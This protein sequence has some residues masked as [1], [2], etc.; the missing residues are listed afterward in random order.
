MMLNDTMPTSGTAARA[1]S[2]ATLDGGENVIEA[3]LPSRA[4]VRRLNHRPIGD[5]VAVGNADFAQR[6]AAAVELADHV[7]GEVEVRIT[8]R[9]ERHERLAA[10]LAEVGEESVE[11]RH[12]ISVAAESCSYGLDR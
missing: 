1:G 9:N 4:R 6:R 10:G 5:R 8:R 3:D 2:A 7:G 12:C 11:A